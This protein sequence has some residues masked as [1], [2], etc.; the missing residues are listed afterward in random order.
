MPPGRPADKRQPY[1]GHNRQPAFDT[2]RS[3]SFLAAVSDRSLRP[4]FRLTAFLAVLCVLALGIFAASPV[5]HAK[6]HQTD[7]S[8]AV[9]VDDADQ[10]EAAT[11]GLPT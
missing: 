3:Y 2:H 8:H 10:A 7:A 5:L 4:L 1:I 6:L 9:P 11:C